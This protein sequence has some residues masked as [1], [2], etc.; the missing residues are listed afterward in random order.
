MSPKFNITNTKAGHCTWSWDIS[1]TSYPCKLFLLG[2]SYHLV[3][4]LVSFQNISPP[5]FCVLFV[6]HI[7]TVYLVQPSTGC[8]RRNLPYF[9]RVFLMLKCTDITQNTYVQSWTVTE[10]MAREKCGLLSVPR[11][12][13]F[14]W[15]GLSVC[16]WLRS[17]I[18][19][20]CISASFVVAA[21]QS[22]KLSQCVMYSAWNSKDSYDMACEFFVVQFNGFTSLTS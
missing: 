5:K 19:I 11:I 21:A 7:L 3:F 6:S 17:L 20:S 10:I 9:G 22:A 16:P 8:P 18:A 4:H 13:R 14:S 12:L 1:I 15:L 2:P